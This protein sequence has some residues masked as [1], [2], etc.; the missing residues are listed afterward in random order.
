MRG[1]K[2]DVDSVRRCLTFVWR[3]W[4]LTINGSNKLTVMRMNRITDDVT[5]VS[6][7]L[8]V[9]ATIMAAIMVALYS[10]KTPSFS[11][12]PSCS[13]LLVVVMVVVA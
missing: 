4:P 5:R 2:T 9:N 10:T 3:A 1:A 12:M 8:Y 11:D 7:Q 6:S 13:V